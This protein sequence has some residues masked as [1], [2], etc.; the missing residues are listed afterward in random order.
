VA[1]SRLNLMPLSGVLVKVPLEQLE[2]R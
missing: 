1:D 2:R